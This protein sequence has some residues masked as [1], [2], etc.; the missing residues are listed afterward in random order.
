MAPYPSGPLHIGN[1]RMVIL[2]DEYVRKYNGKLLL[3][4]DDTIGSKEKG[5][6]PEAYKMIEEDLEWLEVKYH[7]K[8]FKSDRMHIFYEYATQLLE[9]GHAYVCT[10]SEEE[11]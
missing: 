2:N 9:A 8:F 11:V 5:I 3:V 6:L 10:C 4:F 1:A 7:A